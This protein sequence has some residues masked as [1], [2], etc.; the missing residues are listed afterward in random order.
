M[1]MDFEL[2]TNVLPIKGPKRRERCFCVGRDY[3]YFYYYEILLAEVT[4]V[5][6]DSGLIDCIPFNAH[7]H[8]LP[9]ITV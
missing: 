3:H 7:F 8:R 6:S 4:V 2:W 5:S 1:T 9:A